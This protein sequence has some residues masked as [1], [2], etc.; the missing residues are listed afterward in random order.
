MFGANRRGFAAKKLS[1]VAYLS[2]GMRELLAQ[3]ATTGSL[4]RRGGA[5]AKCR[6]LSLPTHKTFVSWRRALR[7]SAFPPKHPMYRARAGVLRRA[8][9]RRRRERVY[10]DLRLAVRSRRLPQE[11]LMSFRRLRRRRSI[12]RLRARRRGRYSRRNAR[13]RTKARL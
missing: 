1:A 10:I 11:R 8:L 7:K 9:R 4:L 2:P 5:G 13:R 12:R 3:R 6:F